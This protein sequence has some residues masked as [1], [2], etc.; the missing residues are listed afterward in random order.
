MTFGTFINCFGQTATVKVERLFFDNSF[1]KFDSIYFDI[2]GT[3]FWGRDTLTKTIKL[4]NDFD[5]C[6]A[7]FG[8]DTLRF[9]T[10]FQNGQE[11]I[12]R[13]GCCCAAFT[14]ESV[15]NSRRGTVIFN[16]NTKNDLGLIVAEAN[17]DTVKAGNYIE[18]FSYESAMCLFK[19]CSIMLVETEYMADQYDY[20]NDNRNYDSLWLEQS[21]YILTIDYF[22]FLHGERIEI[23]Y[24]K[25][26]QR[27]KMNLKGYLTDEEYKQ[28]KN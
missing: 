5:V 11:Y 10:K 15:N 3:E 9:L 27:I 2:N 23:I 17:I 7:I 19:P 21:K 20:Q 13:P 14:L 8:N 28:W 16:N 22:H 6:I 24:E 18:I 25:G 12:L 26:T 1:E 4:N